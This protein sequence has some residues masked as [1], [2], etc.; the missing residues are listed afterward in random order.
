MNATARVDSLR[1]R[2]RDAPLLDVVEGLMQ[3]RLDAATTVADAVADSIGNLARRGGPG[4]PGTVV[5][6]IHDTARQR[7]DA[8]ERL[9]RALGD[10]SGRVVGPQREDR[11]EE[12]VV[13]ERPNV[14][15]EETDADY[16]LAFDVP[17]VPPRDVDV[18]ADDRSV[19]VTA[20]RYLRSGKRVRYQRTVPIPDSTDP[21]SIVAEVRDGVLR[22]ILPKKEHARTRQVPVQTA[23]AG[24][25]GAE[26]APS[27][28]ELLDLS[29]EELNERARREGVEKPEELA[30]KEDVADA[31]LA[32]RASD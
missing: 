20:S 1:R 29:S 18:E 22:V 14:R 23:P 11:E 32:A 9:V 31:I 5:D 30:T 21:T 8:T 25:E 4:D 13:V 26:E 17:G 19:Y 3:A 16:R 6:W 2:R 10:A 12:D 27:R 7:L 28:S 15:V 24:D